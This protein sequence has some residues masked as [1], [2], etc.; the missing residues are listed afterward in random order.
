MLGCGQALHAATISKKPACQ[1]RISSKE[2]TGRPV[3]V[4]HL[5]RPRG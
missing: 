2:R 5:K 4:I 1:K 3:S